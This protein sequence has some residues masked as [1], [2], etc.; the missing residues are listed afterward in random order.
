MGLLT[1]RNAAP[2]RVVDVP[3]PTEDEQELRRT[4]AAVVR[5]LATVENRLR[6]A[7][8]ERDTAHAMVELVKARRGSSVELW[9]AEEAYEAARTNIAGLLRER[10]PLAAQR[11]RLSAYL[12][13]IDRERQE[14]DEL[15]RA[16]A[17]WEKLAE[18][19][20]MLDAVVAVI[21]ESRELGRSTRGNFR[22]PSS[23]ELLVRQ[24]GPEA[25]GA[26]RGS[27]SYQINA[28]VDGHRE[29]VA[30]IAGGL[31]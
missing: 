27:L 11:H 7:E 10:E 28:T 17:A 13:P 4:F 24:Y 12:D 16:L 9:R 31:S 21:E 30:R 22:I 15:R 3:E 23:L 18:V 8:I 26:T 1:P 20:P 2:P 5:Q 14:V 29:R 25:T 6:E 19:L